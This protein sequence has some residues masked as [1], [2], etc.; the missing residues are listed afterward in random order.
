M[1]IYLRFVFKTDTVR[2]RKRRTLTFIPKTS[3]FK[4]LTSH[5]ILAGITNTEFWLVSNVSVSTSVSK[6]RSAFSDAPLASDKLTSEVAWQS[7]INKVK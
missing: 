2:M 3:A 5:D 6:P 7:E 1:D 4:Y